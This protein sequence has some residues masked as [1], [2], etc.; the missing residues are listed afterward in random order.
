MTSRR[1]TRILATLC[2]PKHWAKGSLGGNT[3]K[4]VR[5]A[6]RFLHILVILGLLVSDLGIRPPQPVQASTSSTI[7]YVYDDLGRLKAVTD[8]ASDTAIYS[9]DAVGNVLGISRQNSS[10]V[11]VIQAAPSSAPIGASVTIFGTGFSTTPSQNTV[12]F[13]GNAATVTSSTSTQIVATVPTGATSGPISVTSPSGSATSSTPFTIGN[14]SA[15]TISSF[16]PTIATPGTAV[17]ISGTNFDPSIADDRVAV[18]TTLAQVTSATTSSVVINAPNAGSGRISVTTPNGNAISA[19]DLFIPPSPYSA[20]SVAV[21]GRISFGQS[22]TVTINTAGTVAMLLF[23]G[24]ANQT[25]SVQTTNTTITGCTG[26]NL[27]ILKP[28][29]STLANQGFCGNGFMDIQTLPVDGTYTLVLNPSG[30]NTGNATITL[31]NVVHING[32]ITP[33]GSAVTANITTP[34]QNA[35]YTFSGTANQQVTASTSNV[36]IPGC[37]GYNL[38]ILNPDGSTLVRQGFCG[39]AS[40]ATQTLP[41]TGTYTLV[42]DPNGTNTGQATLALASGGGQAPMQSAANS[43]G[44]SAPASPVA[45]PTA[46]AQAADSSTATP[47]GTPTGSSPRS[48]GAPEPGMTP[49]VSA[50]PS[51][52]AEAKA[53]PPD[54]KEWIP[55]SRNLKGDWTIGLPSPAPTAAPLQATSGV[56]A[57]S[58]IV[59]TLQGQ[60][61][62]GVTLQISDV[63]TQSD[64]NGQFLLAPV[65]AG[66]ETLVIDGSTAN[67]PGHAYGRFEDLV[68]ITNGETNV[69]PYTIWMTRLD[70]AHAVDISS[71]TTSEVVLTDPHIPGLEIHI[72]AG[73]TIKDDDGNVIT[74][75]S[76]TALPVDRPPFPLPPNVND[77]VYF[78]VQPGGAYVG[79]KGAWI[80]Y[81]NYTNLPPARGS[82]SGTTILM[83]RAGTSTDWVPS[84]RTESKS[85]PIRA[86]SFGVSPV[87]CSMAPASCRRRSGQSSSRS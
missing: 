72:P 16:S 13:N 41:T 23:D 54:D 68:Q 51:A 57:L 20:S 18:N 12:A 73:S 84:R 34:G 24:T 80:V 29:G 74:K 86:S 14:L 7:S 10:L 19:G 82:T 77:P 69:L 43:K 15:P 64:E 5:A 28:D 33:G 47:V 40:L 65:K 81:P 62:P 46:E 75:L 39:S 42:L 83:P 32:T 87:R 59:K 6:K 38:A 35:Y 48:S 70:T 27:T 85:S 78:T 63:T 2:C 1:S 60:P 4:R 67:H 61:L 36:T 8:P 55:D 71:P 45:A 30:A 56:T 17:T 50:T 11:S 22:Q 3:E 31:Y 66:F 53:P 37:V 26:Y 44:S 52:K 79:P 21:T 25:V 49:T 58:G 9:Y 76:L